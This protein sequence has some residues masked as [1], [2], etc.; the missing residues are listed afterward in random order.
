MQTNYRLK[1]K[2]WFI[3][4]TKI[5]LQQFVCE[6][7]FGLEN[8]NRQVRYQ[9]SCSCKRV[10]I[11][12]HLSCSS[13]VFVCVCPPSKELITIHMKCNFKPFKPVI[14]LSSYFTLHLTISTM[15]V[16]GLGNTKHHKCLPNKTKVTRN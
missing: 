8:I 14:E 15:D 9:Y 6:D 3:M 13:C 11:K 2:F 5:K 4:Q 12:F 1:G 10:G 16:N 7:K